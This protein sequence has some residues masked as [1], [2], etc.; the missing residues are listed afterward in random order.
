[1]KGIIASEERGGNNHASFQQGIFGWRRK[2]TAVLWRRSPGPSSSRSLLAVRI[3]GGQQ[4]NQAVSG[5]RGAKE[6]GITR[7][8]P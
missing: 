7:A 5:I 4:A 1:M 2:P 8:A 6:L 3:L